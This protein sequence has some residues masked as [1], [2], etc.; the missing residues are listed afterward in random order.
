[1]YYSLTH[2]IQ[3]E[4]LLCV[5]ILCQWWPVGTIL[6]LP[7]LLIGGRDIGNIVVCSLF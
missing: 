6:L 2:I 5:Y 1:M 4:V 3:E 7:L